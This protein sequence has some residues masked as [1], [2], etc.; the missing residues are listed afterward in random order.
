MLNNEDREFI[1]QNIK[2]LL[3]FVDSKINLQ[4]PLETNNDFMSLMCE[5]MGATDWLFQ[6]ACIFSKLNGLNRN[7]AIITGHLIRIRKLYRGLRIHCSENQLELASIFHRLIFETIAYMIYMVKNESNP[8]TYDSFVVTSYMEDRELLFFLKEQDRERE[9]LNIEK[10]MLSSI[11]AEL[12]Q[13]KISENT[14]KNCK[15]S[16]V[17]GKTFKQILEDIGFSNKGDKYNRAYEFYRSASRPI[18]PSWRNMSKYNLIQRG[19]FYFPHIDF[20]SVDVRAAG[21]ITVMCLGILLT[22]TELL[23]EWNDKYL[24]SNNNDIQLLENFKSVVENLCELVHR[25]DLKH[26]ESMESAKKL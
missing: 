23:R 3:E 18:H 22:Y 11:R 4:M 8:E 7:Q 24:S 25:L 9:L 19:D 16:K 5:L 2:E 21:T 6:S 15:H 12:K 13:H 26:E 20:N 10:R 14:L 17:D 1:E